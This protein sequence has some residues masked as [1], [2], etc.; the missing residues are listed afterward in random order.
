MKKNFKFYAVVWALLFALFNVVAFSIGMLNKANFW[1]GYLFIVIS[2][3]GQL[4]CAYLSFKPEKLDRIFLNI[5]VIRIS[6]IGMV[7]SMAISI[8]YMLVAVVPS[9][10]C[11]IL[12]YAILV[13]VAI[14]I[15]KANLAA[16]TVSD[17]GEKIK[18]QTS[19]I[20][21]L[22]ADAEHLMATAKT[23]EIKADAKKVYEAIRYSD[24]M[25]NDAL[26]D[27][28]TKIQYQFN[29][30]TN[31]VKN[32]EAELVASMSVEILDLIDAR[33]KKCK[34]LK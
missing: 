34:V 31:M 19:F 28:E 20:R 33:N 16:E 4:V 15:L 6:F 8:V 9:I 13:F 3:I 23:A 32:E 27:V 21:L 1:L 24:P 25:S 17:V 7:L 30:F 22:T 29:A 2:M 5:P 26:T 14:S 10:L 12:N 18:T 11:I